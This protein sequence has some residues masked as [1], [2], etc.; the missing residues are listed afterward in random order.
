M[1]ADVVVNVPHLTSAYSYAIPAE[2]RGRLGPGHLVTVPLVGRRTQGIVT[3]LTATAAVSKLSQIESLL[4]PEPVLTPAQMRLASWISSTYLAPLSDCMVLI[5]G[6][7]GSE[8]SAGQGYPRQRTSMGEDG[9]KN[10]R[11]L[12]IRQ[13]GEATPAGRPC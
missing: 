2:L 10:T 11:R 3:A 5:T 4:D 9:P 6:Q 13:A 7:I 12:A 8:E 1:F